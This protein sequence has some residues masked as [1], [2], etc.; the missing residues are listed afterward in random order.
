MADMSNCWR[1][2]GDGAFLEERDGELW[3]AVISAMPL[4][5][6]GDEREA[7][8]FVREIVGGNVA[9]VHHAHISAL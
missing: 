6:F 4:A 5:D 1:R 8:A 3:R 7:A 2:L 9:L